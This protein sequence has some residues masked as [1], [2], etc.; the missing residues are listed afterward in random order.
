MKRCI[1][2]HSLSRHYQSHIPFSPNLR[3]YLSCFCT[4]S[5]VA[6]C[7]KA[8]KSGCI[9]QLSIRARGLPY[10][11]RHGDV[12][13]VTVPG[14]L[15]SQDCHVLPVEPFPFEN[16]RAWNNMIQ[17]MTT[18]ASFHYIVFFSTITIIVLV[19][20]IYYARWSHCIPD[21]KV[22]GANMGPIWGRQELF[23]LGCYGRGNNAIF[24]CIYKSQHTRT[25]VCRR[26]HCLFWRR[27][28]H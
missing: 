15:G 4:R 3:Q 25:G 24:E 11:I 8:S 28:P 14:Q 16:G 6:L 26:H 13:Y 12:T 22:H 10:S 20:Y 17:I 23:Y 9:E 2:Y 18:C 5:I 1:V 27:P 21:S 19:E 7:D